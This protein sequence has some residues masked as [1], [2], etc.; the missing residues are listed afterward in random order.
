[1]LT[2]SNE[3]F[4]I[5]TARELVDAMKKMKESKTLKIKPAYKEK[6]IEL[7]KRFND[8]LT[9]KDQQTLP[10]IDHCAPPRVNRNTTPPRVN[11]P[12]V[13]PKM[14]IFNPLN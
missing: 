14:K 1:M 13:P 11:E 10:D 6:L 9:S 7:A 8:T 5:L 4:A 2:L 12:D 3:E